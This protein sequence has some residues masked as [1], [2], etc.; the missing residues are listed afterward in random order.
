M[1]MTLM[2]L[3]VTLNILMLSGIN[4]KV[5]LDIKYGISIKRM[6]IHTNFFESTCLPFS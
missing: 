3:L 5:L 2:T 4:Q 1:T 6:A